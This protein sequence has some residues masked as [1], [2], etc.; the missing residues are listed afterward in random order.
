[1][2]PKL[3][4]LAVTEGVVSVII[5]TLLFAAKYWAGLATGSIA[6][7][8]DAWHTLSDSLTSLV[9]ILGA[10]VASK[11]E[12]KEHPFGHGRAE[13]ISSII[14]GVLLA[15]VGFNFLT[16]SFQ[17]FKARESAQFKSIVIYVFLFSTL[18]KEALARFSFWAGKKT[19]SRS[20]R[21]DGWHH[22]SDA[23][24]S[25]LI[26]AGAVMGRRFWWIDSVLGIAVALLI[27]YA[28]YDIIKG[29]ADPLMGETPNKELRDKIEYLGKRVSQEP[30][31]IHHLH[32]HS[33]G[34]HTELT[35]H[36]R[37][38][39]YM[40]LKTAHGIANSIENAIREE[41][42]MEATIHVEPN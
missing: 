5:N 21:A 35:F 9:V 38:N 25:L 14:I 4:T 37:L 27:L 11:P 31:S 30:L 33:Y 41:L 23:I 15:L 2:L 29:G 12:D 13:L 20:L 6:V 40:D 26:L 7:I 1:M 8:A 3:N 19:N 16:D 22:R 32:I 10:K 17:R 34:S 42:S 24:A 39:R 28:A 36:I 18:V